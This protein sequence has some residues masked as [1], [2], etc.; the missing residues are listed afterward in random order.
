MTPRSLFKSVPADEIERARTIAEEN[1]F[2]A[3]PV[4]QDGEIK[5]YWGHPA[6]RV[7]PIT[8]HHRVPHDTSV[9]HVLPRLNSHFVQFVY[10]RSEVVGLIDLSDLNKPLGRLA[11]FWSFAELE[12]AIF[13]KVLLM[14][15]TEQEVASALGSAGKRARAR[16]ESAKRENVE[17]SLLAFASFPDL[18]KAARTLRAVEVP[19][20]DIGRLTAIRNRLAHGAR[21]LVETRKDGEELLWALGVCRRILK[22]ASS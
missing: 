13:I 12:Q 2:D 19:S 18:L 6:R 5:S 15:L 8:R 21:A 1:N 10:Y 3:V 9:E 20:G 14:G 7:V 4:L 16:R 17:V 11:W 22:I